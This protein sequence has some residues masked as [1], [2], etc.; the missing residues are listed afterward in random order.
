MASAGYCAALAIRKVVLVLW[1]LRCR[2]SVFWVC[3]LVLAN[4][5]VAVILDT[6]D[7]ASIETNANEEEDGEDKPHLFARYAAWVRG[8]N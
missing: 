7:D 8:I 1:L 4:A 6:V 2:L 5:R 3:Q